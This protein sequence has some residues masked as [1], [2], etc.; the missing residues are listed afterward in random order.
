MRSLATHTDDLLAHV[1]DGVAVVTLAEPSMAPDTYPARP[2]AALGE[3]GKLLAVARD[4]DCR[5]P[6]VEFGTA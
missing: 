3:A 4:M 5:R 6:N 1:E 2:A